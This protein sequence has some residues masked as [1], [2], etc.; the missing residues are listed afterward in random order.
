MTRVALV[1]FD[2]YS[3]LFD[4]S[5]SLTSRLREAAGLDEARAAQVFQLWRAK[6]LE[7]AAISNSLALARTSFRDCTRQALG[8]VE[9]RFG[10]A[11][12]EPSRQELVMA[13][14][15]LTP[16]PEAPRVLETLASRG[17]PLALLSNGDRDMLQAL[18]VSLAV[19][20]AHVFS[21]EDAGTYKPHPA[22]YEL[23]IRTLDLER[24]QVL[25]VAGAA[26]DALGSTAAG[27]PCYWSN[28]TGDVPLDPAY[29][30]A[31]QGRSLVGLL[32]L[33][34]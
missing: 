18:A 31:F 9:R 10:L 1:T 5:G 23:P 30:P 8:Y 3:A 2:V 27:I 26:N 6:Q 15:R 21:S 29:A 12:G 19:P 11:L 13:W 34:P 20:F 14:D 22:I 33:L 32:E 4:I 16:W 7:R 24:A 25:H 17:Y 28:R